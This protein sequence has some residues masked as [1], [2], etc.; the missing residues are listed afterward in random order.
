[1]L[2]SSISFHF[3][4]LFQICS[5]K[6]GLAVFS[7]IA[8][9]GPLDHSEFLHPAMKISAI[10]KLTSSHC[11]AH[12]QSDE[13]LKS[14]CW[15]RE[16]LVLVIL[17]SEEREG[18]ETWS[19]ESNPSPQGRLYGS[20]RYRASLHW[21]RKLVARCERACAWGLGG[22]ACKSSL[23]KEEWPKKSENTAWQGNLVPLIN[24]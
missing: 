12:S 20:R 4:P 21:V 16:V 23:A 17:L 5:L 14:G 10:T 24:A 13:G 11:V 6:L 8:K 9:R 2:P 3:F 19:L 7:T 18:L 22:S 1:M 15:D